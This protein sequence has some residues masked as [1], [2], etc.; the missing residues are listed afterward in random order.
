MGR[1]AK[2]LG[3]AVLLVVPLHFLVQD[4]AFSKGFIG[5]NAA[6]SAAVTPPPSVAA[7]DPALTD[8]APLSVGEAGSA[9]A[10]SS[11]Y[12]VQQYYDTTQ[13]LLQEIMAKE[14]ENLDA[15]ADLMANSIKEGRLVH[16]FGTGGHNIMAGMEIFKRAGSLVP[17][18]GIFPPGL[19]V[20]NHHPATERLVGY[21][22]PV[23][24][25]YG[26]QAGDVI[27]VINVN[28]INAVTIDAAVEAREMGLKVIAITSR[29][30]S[31][32]VPAGVPA[33]HPSNADLADLGDILIDTYV[34]VGDAVIDVEGV[35]LK[36]SSIS[37]M[38]NTFVVQALVA[39]TVDKL[40][41]MG[42][43]PEVWASANVEGGTE[44]NRKYRQKYGGRIHHLS[45]Y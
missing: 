13:R 20:T 30:F 12:V 27:L 34:P 16:V 22:R 8:A 33:R 5:G 17:L 15:A 14:R 40:V 11:W 37:T 29:Q 2:L 44:N 6:A 3:G 9:E 28:G 45:F 19:S 10:S 23:L 35:G 18:N 31:N 7:A 25:H 42:V 21:A 26:V 38:T 32:A 39:M 36:V 24:I 1:L 41:R 4:H 43:E